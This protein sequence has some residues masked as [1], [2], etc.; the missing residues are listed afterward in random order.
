MPTIRV[1]EEV[2]EWL[3]SHAEP[4][5]DTPNTVIRRIA[6]LDESLQQRRSQTAVRAKPG[7]LLDRHEYD[8]PILEVLARKGG[9]ANGSEVID[10][11]GEIVADKLTARDKER[12]ESG[13][14]RWRNRAAWRRFNLVKR[15]LLKDQSPRGMWELTDEGWKAA[16]NAQ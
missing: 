5:V 6:G 11:V 1:D 15:G 12:I 10:G 3:K 8:R 14:V 4:F 16:E 9:S 2:Y 7:E 13:V